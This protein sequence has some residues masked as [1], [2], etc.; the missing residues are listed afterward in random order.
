MA[1]RTERERSVRPSSMA[2]GRPIFYGLCERSVKPITV[3]SSRPLEPPLPPPA[4]GRSSAELEAAGSSTASNVVLI[5]ENSPQ[6]AVRRFVDLVD[7]HAVRKLVLFDFHGVLD[8][9]QTESCSVISD[10][11]ATGV[12]VGILSYSRSQD[13]ISNTLT[14]VQEICD[15]TDVMIPVVIAP[16]PLRRNCRHRTD[17]SK[18][19]FLWW[20]LQDRKCLQVCFLEDRGDIVQECCHRVGSTN[21]RVILCTKE[22]GLGHAIR[23]L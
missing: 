5:Q 12:S 22:Q 17:W 14:F 2:S 4:L 6:A 1:G 18:S 10:L 19:D 20:L 11:V 21:L 13:T 7:L 15:R 23:D 9:S 8:L 3:F 16:R